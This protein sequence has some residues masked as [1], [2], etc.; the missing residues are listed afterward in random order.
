MNRGFMKIGALVLL[1]ASLVLFVACG[2]DDAQEREAWERH[3]EVMES[4][5]EAGTAYVLVNGDRLDNA[6]INRNGFFYINARLVAQQLG[7]TVNGTGTDMIFE[8]EG[9]PN[10]VVEISNTGY[11]YAFHTVGLIDHAIYIAEDGEVFVMSASMLPGLFGVAS[12][13]SLASFYIYEDY[14]GGTVAQGH[15]FVINSQ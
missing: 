11:G 10:R 5:L 2:G 8:L 6:L 9:E 14:W 15:V 1:L 12:H 4:W 3:K 13:P 7:W